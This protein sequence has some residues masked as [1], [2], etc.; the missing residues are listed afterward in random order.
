VNQV[1]EFRTAAPRRVFHSRGAGHTR[2]VNEASIMDLVKQRSMLVILIA[3]CTTARTEFEVAGNTVD[4][5]LL[6]DLSTMIARSES[7]LEK[8]AQR[9]DAALN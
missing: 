8:L 4:R 7:E 9:L 3:A 1:D 5:R 6:A 2:L